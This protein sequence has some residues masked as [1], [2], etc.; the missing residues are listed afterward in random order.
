[1]DLLNIK[2]RATLQSFDTNILME[3]ND[4]DTSVV[5]AFLVENLLGLDENL[6]KI[7]FMPDKFS[8][9]HM[10]LNE[11]VINDAHDK[12]MLVVPWTVNDPEM[13]KK[14]IEIGV[15][16]IITDYPNRIPEN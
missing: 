5:T 7:D 10:L 15:D 3:I 11:N 2:D 13:M 4:Q 12:G 8:P 16:G 9:Y 1:L 14:L 6:A